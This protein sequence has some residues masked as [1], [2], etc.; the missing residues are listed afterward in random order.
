MKRLIFLTLMLFGLMF[1]LSPRVLAESGHSASHCSKCKSVC[2]ATLKYCKKKGGKHTEAKHIN[3][4]K[5]CI[6]TCDLTSDFAARGSALHAKAA[7]LCAQACTKCAETCEAF[8]DKQMKDCAAECRSCA[9]MCS[10]ASGCCEGAGSAKQKDCCE[11]KGSATQKDCCKEKA[12]KTK[13][14]AKTDSK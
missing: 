1:A 13:D 14:A 2:E 8:D 10:S 5:D 3:A 11:A 4:L 12:G 7:E 6:K 9:A